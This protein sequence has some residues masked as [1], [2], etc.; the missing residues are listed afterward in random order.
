MIKC[1]VCGAAA[2]YIFRCEEHNRCDDCG[3]QEKICHYKE[4]VLC[5]S[6]HKKRVDER[7]TT[8]NGDTDYT[9]EVTCPYCGYEE[10]DSWEISEGERECGDCG[11]SYEVERIVTVEYSTS[12]VF[13]KEAQS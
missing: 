13:A 4:G 2:T 12:K 7:I 3:T 8:F 6:C 1:R 10:S 11:H 5:R 9:S